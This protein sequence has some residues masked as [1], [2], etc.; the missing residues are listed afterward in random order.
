MSNISKSNTPA[1]VSTAHVNLSVGSGI[2]LSAIWFFTVVLTVF[3]ALLFFTDIIVDNTAAIASWKA[4]GGEADLEW[5][6]IVFVV[7]TLLPGFAAYWITKMFLGK[8]D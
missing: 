1:N 2:A 8:N 3:A 6:F 5:M 7:I 4:E